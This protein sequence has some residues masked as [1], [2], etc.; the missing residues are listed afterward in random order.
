MPYTLQRLA[1]GSYDLLLDRDVVGSVVRSLSKGG[2]IRGCSE[3]RS[4]IAVSLQLRNG[5]HPGTRKMG[6]SQA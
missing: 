6:A 5:Y 1:A 3:R 4:A 2:D